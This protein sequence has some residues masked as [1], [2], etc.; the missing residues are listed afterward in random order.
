MHTVFPSGV[1]RKCIIRWNSL[2]REWRLPGLGSHSGTPSLLAHW[3][4]TLTPARAGLDGQIVLHATFSARSLSDDDEDGSPNRFSLGVRAQVQVCI[5]KQTAAA[6]CQWR[7]P[8]AGSSLSSTFPQTAVGYSF[9][10]QLPPP[11]NLVW[12]L[13][14]AR[15]PLLPL[16]QPLNGM[17]CDT[18]MAGQGLVWTAFTARHRAN[19]LQ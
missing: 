7:G 14:P 5:M 2:S 8:A 10:R 16:L 19:S 6:S 11:P 4:I 15:D 17:N 12:R 18:F 3:V 13:I 1:S 9:S